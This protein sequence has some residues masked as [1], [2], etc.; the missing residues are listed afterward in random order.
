[1]V[2]NLNSTKRLKIVFDDA[3]NVVPVVNNAGLK[4]SGLASEQY[5]KETGFVFAAEDDSFATL[6]SE[7]PLKPKVII[8]AM[9]SDNATFPL[10]MPYSIM[11]C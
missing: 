9:D 8:L 5:T 3:S 6:S 4:P 10:F 11:R 2:P 1:M 7:Q